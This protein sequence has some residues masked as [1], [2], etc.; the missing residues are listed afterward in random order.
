MKKPV[1]R[2]RYYFVD[3]SGDPTFYDSNGNLIV[4]KQGCSKTLILGF[5]C[6][7]DPHAIRTKLAS[8]RN[9]IEKDPIFS[10]VPSMNQTLLAFH[11]KDDLPEVR[12]K[13]YEAL[14]E[15]DYSAQIIVGRKSEA[16]FRIRFKAEENAFYDYLVSK[17]FENV[18]HTS[19]QNKVYFSKRR[20]KDRQKPL[21]L[22]VHEGVR[23]FE[24]KWKA[25]VDVS[26]SMQAQSPSGEPCL[27]AAD[28]VLWA[29]QRAYAKGEMRFFN[30]IRDKVELLI[31][32]FDTAKYPNSYY[33][34]NKNPFDIKKTSPL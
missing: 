12:Y 15:L 33:R 1:E 6:T 21:M 27:Q 28:Y 24:E 14:K 4:G 10:G 19:T 13:V 5:V 20:N 17:L 30:V 25:K 7:K 32:I 9:E 34:K 23:L 16:Q 18:L 29:V 3:E 11:A 31:D 22:A 8:L 26:I 2:C